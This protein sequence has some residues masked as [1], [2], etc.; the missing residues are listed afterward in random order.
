MDSEEDPRV[1]KEKKL[2]EENKLKRLENLRK[3]GLLF[4]PGMHSFTLQILPGASEADPNIYDRNGNGQGL[5]SEMR[6]LW[7]YRF[8]STTSSDLRRVCVYEVQI[9]ETGRV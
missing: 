8:G 9:G 2:M 6:S 3:Q 1:L 7:I 5:E 4:E